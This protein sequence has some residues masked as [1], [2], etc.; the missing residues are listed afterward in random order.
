MSNLFRKSLCMLLAMALLLSGTALTEAIPAADE[1]IVEAVEAVEEVA[2]DVAA[3]DETAETAEEVPADVAAEEEISAQAVEE[4]VGEEAVVDLGE[5]IAPGEPEMAEADLND[6]DEPVLTAQSDDEELELVD[7]GEAPEEAPMT[8]EPEEEETGE[9]VTDMLVDSDVLFDG[10]VKGLFGLRKNNLFEARD[11]GGDLS[12]E[13]AALYTFLRSCLADI[14][15]GRRASTACTSSTG[16][17][18]NGNEILDVIYCL[19][20]DCPYEMF[21]YAS[22]YSWIRTSSKL[23]VRFSVGIPYAT[24]ALD[25]D[26]HYYKVNTAALSRAKTAAA[27]AR[28]VVSQ[29]AYKSDYDKLVAY[30]NYICN[31]VVYNNAA[32]SSGWDMRRMDPWQL[33]WVFDGDRSTNVVCEGYSEAFQYLCDMTSFQG[34]VT[35]YC[36]TGTINGGRHKWNIVRMPNGRNYLVDVTWC[37]LESTGTYDWFFMKAPTSGTAGR[38]YTFSVRNG[39]Y[40]LNGTYYYDSRTAS[41]FRNSDLVLSSRSYAQDASLPTVSMPLPRVRVTSARMSCTVNLGKPFRIDL[42][43]LTA[44]SFKSSKKKVATVNAVGVVT[45]RAVGKT[46]I[47]IK[48]GKAKRTL[49]LKVV[50]PTIPTSVSLN[51]SGTVAARV[52]T[53]VTLRAILPSGTYSGIKWKS[54]NKRIA[55][56]SNG[57]VTFKRKGKVTITATAL[58]GK[59][60]AKVKFKVTP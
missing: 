1:A 15:A 32:M 14:A 44:K 42:N 29:N 43:G 57:V 28:A 49:T 27:N 58:R 34:N 9:D 31:A 5:D 6:V 22:Y 36:V 52:G 50:D 11:A 59:K 55:T 12:G 41:T 40:S 47:T 8:A 56:V 45:P 7:E 53:S 54:S 33:I 2:A 3:A 60:K 48:V 21:W 46:K 19:I 23:T 24:G 25:R 30:R 26:G 20:A 10:Y 51:M 13:K 17:H 16:R 37:D 35:C 4:I 39:N 18:L 38:S